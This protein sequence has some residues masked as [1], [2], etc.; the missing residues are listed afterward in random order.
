MRNV[1]KNFD[2]LVISAWVCFT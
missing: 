1:S 2:I